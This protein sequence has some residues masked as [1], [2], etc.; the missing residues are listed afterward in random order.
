MNVWRIALKEIKAIREIKTIV[1]LILTP[2]L[3]ILILGS[4]LT[5]S[6]HGSITVGDIRVLYKINSAESELAKSWHAFADQAGKTG[7]KLESAN[8]NTDGK[9]E[10][11]NNQYVGY[12]EISDR[13]LN[14]YGNSS[15]PVESGIAQGMITAFANRYKLAS[16]AAENSDLAALMSGN[17]SPDFVKETS[18]DAARQPRALDY[19]A[20]TMVTLIIMFSA[21]PAAE[22]ISSERKRNTTTRLLA[23]PITKAEIFAGKVA[24]NLLMNVVCTVIV[25][26]ICKYM[27]NVYWGENL[28]LVFLV[29]ITEIVFALSVGL[30]FSYIIKGKAAGSVVMMIIQAGAFFGGS[31]FP[32]NEMTGMMKTITQFSPLQWSNTAILQIIYGNGSCT[33]VNA[34]LLNLGLSVFLLCAAVIIMRRREG[35]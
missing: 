3:T 5:N 1:F 20:I 14:Y 26:L 18:L 22:L 15:N 9:L 23:S 25:V 10:V 19:Y 8:E 13:G 35:L 30:G 33:A 34:M 28:G 27:F 31:Y 7:M 24:G 21:L 17:R 29:L 11:A 32:V 6:F 16:A 4:V 2:I 12:V